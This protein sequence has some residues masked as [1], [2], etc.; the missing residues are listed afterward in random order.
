MGRD[1]G[2][3]VLG[4]LTR[5]AAVL[6]LVGIAVFEAVSIAVT[7]VNAKDMATNAA[8]EASDEW[9]K[10]GDADRA[11]HAASAYVVERGGELRPEEFSLAPDGTATVTVRRSATSV[12]LYR[13][14]ATEE[15]LDVAEQ[16]SG[17]ASPS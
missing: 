8:F 14:G 10:T 1:R 5:I 13:F 11:Y 3:V 16:A 9:F 6:A 2:D 7:H 12:L 4:W 15:W 17:K